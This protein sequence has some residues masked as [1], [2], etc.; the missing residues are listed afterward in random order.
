MKSSPEKSDESPTPPEKSTVILLLRDIAD[1]TWR[2]VAPFLAGILIGWLLDERA[3][4]TPWGILVGLV[5]GLAL[6]VLLIRNVYKK[7]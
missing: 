6:S 1:V 4:S 7:L 3:G 5:I 2:L